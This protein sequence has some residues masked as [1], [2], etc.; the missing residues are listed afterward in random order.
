MKSAIHDRVNLS[1]GDTVAVAWGPI[2]EWEAG[3]LRADFWVKIIQ[4]GKVVA[5]GASTGWRFKRGDKKWDNIKCPVKSGERLRRGDADAP[6]G[7]TI[8]MENASPKDQDWPAVRVR[9]E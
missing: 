8:E 1:D 6:Y 4:D 3:E 2:H 5:E 9:L 7:A